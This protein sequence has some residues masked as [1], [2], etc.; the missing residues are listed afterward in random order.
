MPRAR[1]TQ[2]SPRTGTGWGQR[3][4]CRWPPLLSPRWLRASVY[5]LPSR[6]GAPGGPAGDRGGALVALPGGGTV[7]RHG[8]DEGPGW[9][10]WRHPE[11]GGGR[12]RLRALGGCGRLGDVSLGQVL[13]GSGRAL[14]RGTPRCHPRITL[15]AST[16]SHRAPLQTPGRHWDALGTWMCPHTSSGTSQEQG[17]NHPKKQ[18]SQPCPHAATRHSSAK[19]PGPPPGARSRAPSPRRPWGRHSRSPCQS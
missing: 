9:G 15:V 2:G 12:H 3:S 19:S 4:G 5:P 6:A 10:G 13:G 14:G 16:D 18:G 8:G 17:P 1:G 7:R 11:P